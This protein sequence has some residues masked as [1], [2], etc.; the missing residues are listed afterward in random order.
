MNR[1]EQG[2]KEKSK[3]NR[4][5]QSRVTDLGGLLG[6][7]GL[8][9][10]IVTSGNKPDKLIVFELFDSTTGERR[11]AFVDPRSQ[12]IH[13]S[14]SPLGDTS[15]QMTASQGNL[16]ELGFAFHIPSGE[17]P[18]HQVVSFDGSEQNTPKIVV[19]KTVQAAEEKGHVTGTHLNGEAFNYNGTI[20]VLI[21][22][23]VAQEGYQD[24]RLNI[25]VVDENGDLLAR[26]NDATGVTEGLAHGHASAYGDLVL[27]HNSAREEPSLVLINLVTQQAIKLSNPSADFTTHPVL[28]KEGCYF[29]SLEDNQLHVN[30][31]SAAAGEE[32]VVASYP[33]ET[34][35]ID[36]IANGDILAVVS[37][38]QGKRAI[39]VFSRDELIHTLGDVNRVN[40]IHI[41]PDLGVIYR[42]ND[43][44]FS[45]IRV[46]EGVEGQ[47]EIANIDF[48]PQYVPEFLVKYEFEDQSPIST[49]IYLVLVFIWVTKYLLRSR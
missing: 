5:H 34:I 27:L 16:A 29:V 24:S 9:V 11:F 26:F 8:T 48:D 39:D 47:Q 42:P 18:Y 10:N 44:Q 14:E 37:S 22:E 35:I 31:F 45:V 6:L 30:A 4:L 1:V 17:E 32:R 38:Q 40:D 33:E 3:L 49:I 7:A 41:D 43:N 23:P 21:I 25:V 46:D 12:K 13:V 28:A 36:L 20:G 2:R 15:A 19:R